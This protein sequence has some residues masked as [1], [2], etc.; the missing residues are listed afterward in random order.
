MKMYRPRKL[1]SVKPIGKQCLKLQKKRLELFTVQ[2][3]IK[4]V[5]VVNN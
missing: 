3:Q 4:H 2:S 1:T 5:A